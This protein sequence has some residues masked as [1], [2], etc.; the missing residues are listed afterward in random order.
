MVYELEHGNVASSWDADDLL[1]AA[2]SLFHFIWVGVFV[3]FSSGR[4]F[5]IQFIS[6]SPPPPPWKPLRTRF[7]VANYPKLCAH[8]HDTHTQ[9][10]SLSH[11]HI[12]Q[13]T[14]LLFAQCVDRFNGRRP[15]AHGSISGPAFGAIV[16]AADLMVGARAPPAQYCWMLALYG[17]EVGVFVSNSQFAHP[18]STSCVIYTRWKTVLLISGD[19]SNLKKKY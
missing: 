3:L 19:N 1:A 7:L 5:V 11:A 13:K 10:I 9:R 18:R 14:I 4:N 8:K 12:K 2:R 15:A 17:S 6:P 16:R